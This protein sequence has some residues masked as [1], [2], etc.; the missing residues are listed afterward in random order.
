MPLL[1]KNKGGRVVIVNLQPTKHDK[2]CHLKINAYIDDVMRHVCDAIGVT[3]APVSKPHVTLT[4][5]HIDENTRRCHIEVDACLIHVKGESDSKSVT[6]SAEQRGKLSPNMEEPCRSYKDM[7]PTSVDI[8]AAD[9]STLSTSHDSAKTESRDLEL[10]SVQNGIADVKFAAQT[11]EC[12]GDAE[13]KQEQRNITL[14]VPV[15]NTIDTDTLLL[16]NDFNLKRRA[17]DSEADC[18]KVMKRVATMVTNV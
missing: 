6:I 7:K 13:L 5:R 18:G 8:K 3:V 17:T 14:T 15:S 16:N 11:G 4:S 12:T 10:P 2:A 1:T 9:M